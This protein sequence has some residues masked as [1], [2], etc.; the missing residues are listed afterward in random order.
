[1]FSRRFAPKSAL[2]CAFASQ[3][4]S[5]LHVVF[6]AYVPWMCPAS[7]C[8]AHGS[9][10]HRSRLSNLCG[11][12]ARTQLLPSRGAKIIPRIF[13]IMTGHGA[14]LSFVSRGIPVFTGVNG[15]L[16]ARQCRV[17]CRRA[18]KDASLSASEVA[19]GLPTTSASQLDDRLGLSGC[20]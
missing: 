9:G 5:S 1:M 7:I 20:P 13:R 12:P 2:S 8:R 6:G 11:L 17:V 16:M 15:V 14:D 19:R 4:F 18:G 10:G 3:Q